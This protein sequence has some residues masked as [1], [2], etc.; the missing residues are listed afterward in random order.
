MLVQ[1]GAVI[2]KIGPMEISG[3]WWYGN[4]LELA[5]LLKSKA[6]FPIAIKLADFFASKFEQQWRQMKPSG[7]KI[8][9]KIIL[10]L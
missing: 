3:A 2:G 1:F 10:I 7:N 4:P 8:K 5:L 6:E 9:T